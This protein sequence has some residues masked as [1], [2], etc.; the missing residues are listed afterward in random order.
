V[1]ESWWS[2]ILNHDLWYAVPLIV[3]IALVYAGTRHEL[4]PEILRYAVRVARWI[5]VFMLVLLAIL[6]VLAW[7]Q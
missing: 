3:A 1:Q 6:I 2:W 4:L 5:V 7:F